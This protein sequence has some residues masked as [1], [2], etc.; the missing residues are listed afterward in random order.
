MLHP[1]LNRVSDRATARTP[2]PSR[3]PLRWASRMVK[4]VPMPMNMAFIR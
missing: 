2:P 3:A 1:T 4:A